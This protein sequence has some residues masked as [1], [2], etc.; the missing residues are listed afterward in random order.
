[1]KRIYLESLIGLFACFMASIFAYE[2][3][4]YQWTTDYEFVLYDYEAL[5]HQQLISN[6][7]TNQGVEAAEEA[8][9][10][11]ADMTRHIVTTFPLGLGAPSEV[12][13]FFKAQSDMPVL[14]DDDRDLW[15]HFPGSDAIYRYAPDEEAFVR[16]KIQLE[17]DLLWLFFSLSFVIY[18][19]GHLFVIHRRVKKLE[20]ATLGFASGDFSIR[21]ETRSGSAIGTLNRSFNLMADKIQHLIDSNRALTNA[22]AHELRTPV[23]RIQWQAELLKDTPLDQDQ[24]ATIDSI[25]EDTEEMEGM[26]DELLYF[27]KLDNHKLDLEKSRFE[28]STYVDKLIP[29]WQKETKLTLAMTSH[30]NTDH[31]LD[32][33]KHQLKRALD[34]VVRNAFKFAESQI[35]IHLVEKEKYLCIEIHD[36]GPG[37]DEEHIAHLFEP[38]YVGNKARNKGKSGHGLGLSIVEK[39][40]QQHGG[41]ASVKRSAKLNG[42]LFTLCLPKCN[43]EPD[44]PIQ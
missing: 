13:E 41:Y 40:C 42:A 28:L 23:F 26:V 21:A 10:Q 44:K 34:N 17:D 16:Q 33:D 8:I 25:V 24:R 15:F 18:A 29:R 9:A 4:V 11:F 5:A 14:F 43:S 3:T 22:V 36:D 12:V 6:I 2:V 1:M 7:A 27:A 19:S 39:I 32:A 31:Q 38:F 37:V 30:L 35:D 20:R